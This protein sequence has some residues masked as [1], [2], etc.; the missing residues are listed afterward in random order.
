MVTGGLVH[1]WVVSSLGTSLLVQR[2]HGITFAAMR[3][4]LNLEYGLPLIMVPVVAFL[5]EV[6]I[7]RGG[8]RYE[9]MSETFP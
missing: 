6:W 8:C 9:P 1:I 3:F 4:I 7:K 5:N 2:A